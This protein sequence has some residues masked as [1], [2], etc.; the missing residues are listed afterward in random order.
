M[1]S[2]GG[3]RVVSYRSDQGPRFGIVDGDT[4]LDAGSDI[5]DLRPGRDV[6]AL[7]S[8]D[9]LAPVPRPGKV[10]CVGR[11]YAEHARETGAAVPDRP[12]LFAKWA[13][14]VAGPRDDVELPTIT[15][16]LD[17]E[18]ELV[19]VI[20][21]SAR[22]V[23]EADALDVVLGYTCGDDVSARDLQFGDAQWVRGKT[24]DG[25]APTGPWIVTADEIPDPQA[26][27]IRCRV[28]G[29]L[30]QD[31]T[32]AHMLFGVATLIAF[33]TEAITLEPGDL[34]FTGTPPGVGHGMAPPRYLAV[35]DEVTVE[36]DRIG[37]LSH[38]IVAPRAIG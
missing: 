17:Y 13:N 3:M 24:L 9:L 10:V 29:E 15:D 20:G 16:A 21:R 25:F 14:A 32:T 28:N 33:V 18:A 27:G 31:D 1:R 23:A 12:Q 6:G 22:H 30:R 37:A 4:V 26:L 19:V 11:N 2:V 35:G 36:I 7:D 34:I 38:R 8:V 5:A